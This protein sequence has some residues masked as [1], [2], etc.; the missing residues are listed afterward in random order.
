M[1]IHRIEDSGLVA[2]WEPKDGD[3]PLSRNEL[4]VSDEDW[5]A[6]SAALDTVEKFEDDFYRRSRNAE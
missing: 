2:Y 5:S 3:G 6:Y 1:R 4:E